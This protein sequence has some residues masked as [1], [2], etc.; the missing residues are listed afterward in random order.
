MDIYKF[1]QNSIGKFR[2]P[3]NYDIPQ[4]QNT[5]AKTKKVTTPA[6]R[7]SSPEYTQDL[8]S[9]LSS[10]FHKPDFLLEFIP[11]IRKLART[12]EDMGSV[13]NDLIQLTNTGHT[14]AF[15]PSI[16]PD[17]VD[18]MR[19]HLKEKSKTWGSGVHGINGLVNKW[20]GQVWISGALS[21]EW[22]PSSELDGILNVALV[23]PENILF[24]Y[25]KKTTKY[26]PYQKVKNKLL[27]GLNGIENA[28]KLNENT[29]FYAG[30]LN[31]TDSPY[32]IPPFLTALEALSDQK[33]MKKNIN[34]ILKQVGLLGY[35]EVKTD[36]P[37]Q[38]ADESEPAYIARLK[39]FLLETKKSVQDGF[40]EGVVVGFQD[41]HDFEFHS[42]TKNI[43][44]VSEL[45]NL[46][47]VQVANGLKTSPS[48]I[49]QKSG[50]TETN[51]GIVFTKMLSQLNSVQ[52]ILAENLRKGYLLELQ[53]AGFETKG[54]I[55]VEFK[56]STITDD[57][58]WWQAMEIKQ[59][60]A[61]KMRIDNIISQ[62]E[63]ANIMGYDKPNAAEPIVPYKDQ[64]GK[65]KEQSPEQK[66][67]REAGKDK[68]DRTGRDKKKTQPRRN[69]RS[70]KE[71]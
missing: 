64:L 55:R 33:L 24:K 9:I 40:M 43:N 62:E 63:Y 38:L 27:S 28:V 3:I 36:K 60:T 7:V 53:L 25:N 46:N 58:K 67:K 45:F 49:G 18:K 15:D 42:T 31:D 51:M 56:P 19:K 13:Y 4:N 50:G 47:E 14:V 54:Q 1:F 68:S 66:T 23:N 29:Y 65:A 61:Q 17:Q 8:P 10:G 34:H 39:H 70:T 26:E 35:L 41:D 11:R 57:L 69:D 2:D 37:D 48:F 44:G 21:T 71:R 16:S 30:I 32:G 20:V 5:I 59:R 22:I 12:N 52:E 6:G